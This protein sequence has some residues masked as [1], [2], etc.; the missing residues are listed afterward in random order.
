MT[1]KTR[2]LRRFCIFIAL[3][4]ALL[5]VLWA[6]LRYVIID[7]LDSGINTLEQ[8]GYQVTHDGIEVNGFP[9][10]LNTHSQNISIQAPQGTYSDP[11]KNWA[12]EL[13]NI[14]VQSATYMPLR[15]SLQHTGKMVVDYRDLINQQHIY[16]LS[17]AP[18]AASVTVGLT[19][20]I[21]HARYD[22]DQTDIY[23]RLG[24]PL[25]V[26]KIN[27]LEGQLDVKSNQGFIDIKGKDIL[28]RDGLLSTATPVFGNV[29]SQID[30][31]ASLDNWKTLQEQG[32]EMWAQEGGRIHAQYWKIKWGKVDLEG[33]FDLTNIKGYP[34]GNISIKIKDISLLMVSLSDAGLIP[35][36]YS[37]QITTMLKVIKKDENDRQLID[38]TIKDGVVKYGFITLFKLYED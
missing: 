18:L 13:E 9:L 38:I 21:K 31:K 29:I 14:N 8:Q 34:E 6:G 3:V 26:S 23:T 25:P 36:E 4:F 1:A 11:N 24:P 15:W 28:L 35:S 10:K 5:C 32:A 12:L 22:M 20:I 2:W 7:Q 17:P 33:D 30:I 16:E 37:T 19:G 27:H